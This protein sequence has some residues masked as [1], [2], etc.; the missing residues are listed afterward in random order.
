MGV[1]WFGET[2]F[3]MEVADVPPRFSGYLSV[4]GG[5]EIWVVSEPFADRGWVFFVE[6]IEFFTKLE[7]FTLVTVHNLAVP[8]HHRLR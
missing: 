7:Q 1:Y 6:L 4:L 3:A 5:A 2:S 8:L